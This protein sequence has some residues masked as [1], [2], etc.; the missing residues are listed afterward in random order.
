MNKTLCSIIIPNYNGAKF[1]SETIDSVLKQTYKNFEI[2][3]IDDGSTDNSI[4]KIQTYIEKDDRI[5]YFKRNSANKGASV[6]RNIGIEKAKGDYIIFLDSDDILSETCIEKRIEIMH[7]NPS[8][9]FAVFNM[10]VFH[11]IPGDTDITVNKYSEKNEY[12]QMFIEYNLPWQT[13]CPIWQASFLKKNHIR[14]DGRYQRLQD[15]EFHAKILMKFSPEFMVL[16]NQ[17]P[18]CFYRLPQPGKALKPLNPLVID[19]FKQYYSDI[20]QLDKA[21][22]FENE[23]NNYVINSLH[24]ILFFNK[25]NTFTPI[26]NYLN[27]LEI[28]PR[29]K[30]TCYFFY[31]CN[32]FGLTFKKGFGVSRLW[33]M[34]SKKRS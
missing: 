26:A 21:K 5:K 30:I 16:K 20:K 9:D 17:K 31:L 7:N 14:F 22:N 8:L 10:A 19:G 11:A 33:N 12:L 25:L 1:V 2:L 18:D 29:N 3:L 27:F 13:S 4:E 15:P 24:S 34:L 32:K 28:K 23:L 6:C